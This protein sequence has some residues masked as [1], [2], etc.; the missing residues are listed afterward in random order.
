[1]MP[2]MTAVEMG[3]ANLRGDFPPGA[4]GF[5][6]PSEAHRFLVEHTGV[7][8]GFDASQWQLWLDANPERIPAKVSTVRDA[9]KAASAMKPKKHPNSPATKNSTEREE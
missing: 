6:V 9:R 1:M 3:I 5:Q 4:I 2:R 8:F 7:D